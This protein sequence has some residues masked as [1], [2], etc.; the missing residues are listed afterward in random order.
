M[1]TGGSSAYATAETAFKDPASGDFTT[2]G[3]DLKTALEAVGTAV[4]AG[5]TAAFPADTKDGSSANPKGYAIWAP[6]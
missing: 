2:V 6:T 1:T 4:T 3:S 5:K